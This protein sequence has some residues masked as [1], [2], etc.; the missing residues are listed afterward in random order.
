MHFLNFPAYPLPLYL[1]VYL[2]G[3]VGAYMLMTRLPRP[4]GADPAKTAPPAVVRFRA[5]T[6]AALWPGVLSVVALPVALVV[7]FGSVILALIPWL[8]LG[9][10]LLLGTLII[11]SVRRRVVA[12]MERNGGGAEPTV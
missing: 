5:A 11:P 8:A 6:L 1:A 4:A 7:V 9:L 2:I 10:A 12:T 3:A